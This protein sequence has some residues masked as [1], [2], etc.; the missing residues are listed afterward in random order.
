MPCMNGVGATWLMDSLGYASEPAEGASPLFSPRH[1]D[2]QSAREA[3][4]HLVR[5]DPHKLGIER[6][7]WRL[8]DLVEQLDWQVHTPAG[9][10]RLL[11]RL[12]IHYKRGRSYIHSPDPCYEEKCARIERLK[13]R[14]QDSQG[15]EVLVYLDECSVCRQPSVGYSWEEAGS[16]APHAE[17]KPRFDTITRIMGTLDP[18]SG[19]VVFTLIGKVTTSA[20]VSFYRKVVQA[21]P[22]AERIWVVQDNWP[23]HLHPDVLAAL[24][25]QEQLYPILFSP[26]WMSKT[27]PSPSVQRRQKNELLPIQI[28]QLPT[29]ASW[30]NP[31]EKLWRWLKQD[32]IHLHRLADDLEALRQEIRS[33]LTRF[34]TGSQELLRYAGLLPD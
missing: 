25:P 8:S 7:R 10:Q 27:Q 23:V 9:V 33:F 5:R 1:Q 13:Q 28:V 24:Q 14:V 6:S 11:R 31:I 15:R 18:H 26:S 34:D 29:Y 2:E 19:K 30:C 32:H 3:V 22:R 17:W 21:Y 20:L 4:L 16:D 12:D